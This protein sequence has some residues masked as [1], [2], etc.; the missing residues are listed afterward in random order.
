MFEICI[1]QGGPPVEL[2]PHVDVGGAEIWTDPTYTK[3]YRKL[4]EDFETF[5][6]FEVDHR[7]QVNLTGLDN[8]HAC[9]FF[10]YFRVMVKYFKCFFPEDV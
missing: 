4:F 6:S 9:T 8:P 7:C 2:P 10:R 3:I 5:D 1:F